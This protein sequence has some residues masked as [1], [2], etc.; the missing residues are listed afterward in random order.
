[1]TRH[2][3]AA[4][5]SL[6]QA[7]GRE[8]YPRASESPPAYSIIVVAALIFLAFGG[9][10]KGLPAMASMGELPT[11]VAAAII[12]IALV[13]RV[14][15]AKDRPKG[16]AWMVLLVVSFI[17]GLIGGHPTSYTTNKISVGI[18][19]MLLS[20][21]AGLILLSSLRDRRIWIVGLAVFGCLMAVLTQVFPS[22]ETVDSLALEGGNTI[23][24]GRATGAAAVA[25]F[26]LAL[27]SSRRRLL[28][29]V[30]FL[31]VSA[32]M[33]LA[34]S[35]GP[36]L[37]LL[38]AVLIAV[39]VSPGRSRSVRLLLA[40][41]ALGLGAFLAFS[42]DLVASRLLTVQDTSAEARRRLWDAS[43]DIIMH[44]PAGI[45]WGQL[46]NHLP[47]SAVLQ[48]VGVYQYPHNVYLEVTVEGGWI[49]G[50]VLVLLIGRSAI[51][52]RRMT[53]Q[54][55]ESVMLALFIF[56]AVNAMVSGDVGDN[57][58]LWIAVGA[59]MAGVTRS[60]NRLQCQ[61]EAILRG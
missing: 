41:L 37:S 26:M 16:L 48:S 59:G 14:V 36:V 9:Y 30:T 56:F 42:N 22:V 24:L 8:C 5:R 38:V 10:V 32:F 33:I 18:P 17:P 60:A 52:Q 57:R 44:N 53:A 55:L 45:G 25:L 61:D 54:P 19:L 4:N 28:Y 40:S 47:P 34:G 23:G 3:Q 11:K 58:G 13:H 15:V 27:T 1:M 20:M 31:G 2:L 35:R 7:K 6:S 46:Y 49:A 29:S 51:L 39:S 12:A 50:L 43:I 21:A